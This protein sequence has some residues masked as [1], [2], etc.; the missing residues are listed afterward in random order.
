M[1][2]ERLLSIARSGNFVYSFEDMPARL[3]Y[4]GFL[5]R[6]ATKANAEPE[7]IIGSHTAQLQQLLLKTMPENILSEN[8]RSKISKEIGTEADTAEG[9]EAT[10]PSSDST[11]TTTST[12]AAPGKV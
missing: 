8:L 4:K 6:D 5:L 12:G 11:S 2:I 9:Q 10:T 7:L 3:G 1:E